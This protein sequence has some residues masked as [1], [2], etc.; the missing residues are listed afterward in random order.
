MIVEEDSNSERSREQR[1][2]SFPS[3]RERR[4]FSSNSKVVKKQVLDSSSG[5]D[6]S[7]SFCSRFKN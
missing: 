7:G 1:R 3:E 6:G 2:A 4:A 5:S